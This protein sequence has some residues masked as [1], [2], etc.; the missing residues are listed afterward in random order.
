MSEVKF[1]DGWLA[2][3]FTDLRSLGRMDE[4]LLDDNVPE[5]YLVSS[6]H[7][8]E[9]IDKRIAY[10]E[11]EEAN[12]TY[13]TRWVKAFTSLSRFAP[14]K[15]MKQVYP[16]S[17]S[18]ADC[19]D[20]YLHIVTE[21]YPKRSLF[22]YLGEDSGNVLDETQKMVIIYG[23]AV[24]LMMMEMAGLVHRVLRPQS[25]MLDD[26]LYPHVMGLAN[27]REV[28]RDDSDDSQSGDVLGLDRTSQTGLVAG[29]SWTDC[30]MSPEVAA[31][32]PADNRA[33]SWSWAMV[34]CYVLGA[35]DPN[36]SPEELRDSAPSMVDDL[37]VPSSIRGLLRDCLSFNPDGRPPPSSICKEIWG[38]GDDM[39]LI[40]GVEIEA[41]REYF[42]SQ[43][44]FQ[45]G[46]FEYWN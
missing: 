25:I 37:D 2:E 33:D 40:E 9:V 46:L 45:D 5:I 30:F 21:Y 18:R 1:A 43:C 14:F 29:N 35:I 42:E 4:D 11:S 7:I 3:D 44:L 23:V 22:D 8:G 39:N 12:K 28:A 36:L 10:R 15:Y 6:R 13:M 16:D 24:Q 26:Q 19:G 27:I 38:G 32:E 31:R 17:D 20:Y 41:I 34:T